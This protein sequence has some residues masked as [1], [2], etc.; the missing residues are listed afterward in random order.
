MYLNSKN[1]ELILDIERYHKIINILKKRNSK[2]FYLLRNIRNSVTRKRSK[3]EYKLKK[4]KQLEE[5]H[6]K[7]V[8]NTNIIGIYK[9]HIKNVEYILFNEQKKIE[10]K[11]ILN[12]CK[13]LF[14]KKLKSIKDNYKKKKNS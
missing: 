14:L 9:N 7:Y 4:K 8:N 12:E 2:L 5:N 3:L 10:N 11:I 13:N 6:E 1:R